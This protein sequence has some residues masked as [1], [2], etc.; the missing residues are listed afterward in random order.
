MDIHRLNHRDCEHWE[1][2]LGG[3]I[4]IFVGRLRDFVDNNLPTGSHIHIHASPPCQNLSLANRNKD[5]TEG[6]R[7]VLWT[8]DVIKELNPSSWTME[9]VTSIHLIKLLQAKGYKFK[10]VDMSKY[11]VCQTRRRLFCGTVDFSKLQPEEPKMLN[12]IMLSANVQAPID[13]DYITSGAR[14]IENKHPGGLSSYREFSSIAPTV[15]TA[16][17][18]FYD[19]S[20][21]RTK[22]IPLQLMRGLQTIPVTYSLLCRNNRQ[23]IAN[24]VPPQ[25]AKNIIECL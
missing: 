24:C 13:F 19:K 7:M 1:E 10:V 22:L 8:L 21:G 6:L 5:I 3:D 14:K 23:M 18:R 11:G 2:D 17:P 20:T 4:N 9:Q 25:M 12:D 16:Y 15:C